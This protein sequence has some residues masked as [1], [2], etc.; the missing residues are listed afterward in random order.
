MKAW[1]ASLPCPAWRDALRLTH[2]TSV[3]YLWRPMHALSPMPLR[4]ALHTQDGGAVRA[5]I[6][7][8]TT[9]TTGRTGVS[10]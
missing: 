7:T 1:G 4:P 6:T 8:G 9:S 5:T 2:R 3:A 10:N